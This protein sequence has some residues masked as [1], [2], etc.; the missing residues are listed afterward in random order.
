M[1]SSKTSY[2][3]SLSIPE[4]NQG[5]H[6][7]GVR[8]ESQKNLDLFYTRTVEKYF[9]MLHICALQTKSMTSISVFRS[10]LHRCATVKSREINWWLKLWKERIQKM[11]HTVFLKEKFNYGEPVNKRK[12]NILKQSCSV[13]FFWQYH[14]HHD[15]CWKKKCWHLKVYLQQIDT[16]IIMLTILIRLI[17]SRIDYRWLKMSSLYILITDAD[18]FEMI[19]QKIY[20][21]DV[22]NPYILNNAKKFKLVSNKM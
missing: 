17:N 22:G 20:F 21:C 9:K 16:E 3:A 7:S 19:W 6:Y 18:Y 12:L 1:S 14:V 4:N 5:M 10:R 2:C 13:S 8:C 15:T 11:S